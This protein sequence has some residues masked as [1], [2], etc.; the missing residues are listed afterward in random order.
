VL[1]FSGGILDGYFAC[2]NIAKDLIQQ[3]NVHDIISFAY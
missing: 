2:G 3:F 1:E